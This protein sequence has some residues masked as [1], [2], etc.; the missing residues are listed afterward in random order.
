[1]INWCFWF[2]HMLIISIIFFY[3]V[4]GCSWHHRT[5]HRQLQCPRHATGPLVDG[6]RPAV[7]REVWQTGITFRLFSMDSSV[8]CLHPNFIRP[9]F[10]LQ[11]KLQ[12]IQKGCI[13]VRRFIKNENRTPGQLR[14]NML[15]EPTPWDSDSNFPIKKNWQKWDSNSG[16]TPG[17]KGKR[18]GSMRLRLPES[19]HL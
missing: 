6:Q 19:S 12:I 8:F 1:M 7:C 11:S 13:E 4:L 9:C 17:K 14:P 2:R 5:P 16:A 3:S 18:V 15:K 10:N